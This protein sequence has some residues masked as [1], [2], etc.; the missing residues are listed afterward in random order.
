MIQVAGKE[1]SKLFAGHVGVTAAESTPSWPERN[2]PP[3]AAPNVLVI[4]LDDVGFAQMGS[5]GA[6]FDTPNMDSLA[7]NGLRYTNFHVTSLCS[8]TRAS[9]LTG[10]NH[11]SVGMGCLADFDNGY[12]SQTGAITHRAATLAEMLRPHGY[13]NYCVGKWHVVPSQSISPVGPFDQW[14]LGRGFDHYYGFLWGETDQWRPELWRDNHHD[15][16]PLGEGYHL[17]E[18]LVDECIHNISDHITS[19]SK[20]PFF[21]YLAFGAAHAPHQA[22]QSYIDKYRGRFNDGWDATRERVLRKQI[23]LGVVP[24]GTHLS[25]RNHDVTA[26]NDL[27]DDQRRL[28][29]RMQEVFAAFMDHT[30]VQV[31]QLLNFLRVEGLLENTLTILMSDNGASGEGGESGSCNEYRYFL[32][33]PDDLTEN[34][35]VIDELGSP[36][37][38]NHY[39]TGW[40]Q[41]GNT[42]GKYYKKFTHAGGVRAPFI[43][44]W[45]ERITQPGIR[46]GFRHVI[47]VVPTILDAIGVEAPTSVNGVTQMPVHGRSFVKSLEDANAPARDAAQYFEMIGNRAIWR[48]GWKAVTRH[49]EGAAYETDVWELYRLDDD[50]SETQDLADRYPDVLAE[51]R[52]LW[53][54]EARAY[55]VFPL[56]DRLQGRA[57]VR[58]RTG[59]PERLTFRFL[60]GTSPVTSQAAP[61]FYD[62]S[63]T[64]TASVDRSSAGQDGVLIAQGHHANGWSL[65]IKE[66]RLVLDYNLAGR[67]TIVR[68][69]EQLPLEACALTLK[70]R[71]VGSKRALAT[72]HVDGR[73]VAGDEVTTI[74]N[75][76]GTHSV[77]CGRNA[78]SP[79]SD[80]YESPFAF[81][82]TLWD[83]AVEL[84]DDKG[85][86][87][88]GRFQAVLGCE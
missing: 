1:P 45:P 65:F 82:G 13:Q 37:T 8:P 60:P 3:E 40:A 27:S 43:V 56:D 51:L 20:D 86:T 69:E 14:P 88:D 85:T 31:G 55:D 67:H 32:Q 6:P 4:V 49:E 41:A 59:A 44:H 46:T 57:D 10:R 79:V 25:P 64:V 42:P 84:G 12:P 76:F 81:S 30:D 53:W 52:D 16:S 2:H 24:T 23:E 77:Q 36:A 22:P 66:N 35:A 28:F 63:F 17:S 61:D 39:P 38:H 11:H 68:S 33:Q 78:P 18:D 58:P 54:A 50:F 15:R 29:A 75:F 19:A 71:R 48:D 83:V 70:M 73:Q 80:E 72:L 5:F 7:A 62:R 34:L 87:T 21:M 9:L 74:P 26:W 47:D